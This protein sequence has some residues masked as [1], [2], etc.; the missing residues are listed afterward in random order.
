MLISVRHTTRF[1]Y[2]TRAQYGIQSLRLTPP[3]FD[4]QRVV[5]W[6][7]KAPGMEKAV[8]FLDS[9][10]NIVHLVTYEG[11]H[12]EVEVTA[13]GLVETED[14]AG[15][16]AG[17]PEPAPK[18]VYLRETTLTAPDEAIRALA[19]DSRSDDTV[20]GMHKLM[21]AVRD[22]VDYTVGATEPQTTAAAAL[23]AKKGVCQDHAHIFISAVRTLGMPARYV[24]GYL[25]D[26]AEGDAEA[27]HAWGEVWL[28]GLG[29]VGFDP[30]NR[31]CPTDRYVRL[32]WGLDSV[33][34]APIRG[35]RRGGDA[36]VL[37][38]VV[39]VEQQSAQQQN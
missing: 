8:S 18:R 10:G 4:G 19:V 26:G 3:S 32:A 15:V 12:D 13:A 21:H 38:V 29:W 28:E 39:Q 27:H 17:L 35:R 7:L 31:V 25:L 36:E 2:A 14:R 9:Y 16:T 23:A 11:A 6:T 1:R 30:A 24:N 34:A 20:A 22:A 37:D 5:Q 33:S